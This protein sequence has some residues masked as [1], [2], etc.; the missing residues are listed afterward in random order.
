MCVC[1]HCG[2]GECVCDHC[3]G[4]VCVCAIPT[5]GNDCQSWKQSRLACVLVEYR[6]CSRVRCVSL[7]MGSGFFIVMT[8]DL[9]SGQ[10]SSR[11][12]R[13]VTQSSTHCPHPL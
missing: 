7:S 10:E 5:L 6:T 1:D 3:G 12:W 13:A 8:F 4:G 2:G 11:P 9:A